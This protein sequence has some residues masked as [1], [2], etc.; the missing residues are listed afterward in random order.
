M[1]KSKY[2]TNVKDK[3][4][5]VEAWARKGLTLDNTKSNIKTLIEI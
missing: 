2:E 4:L 5:L 1:A 3:L